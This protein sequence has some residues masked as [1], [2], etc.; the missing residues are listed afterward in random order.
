MGTGW[1]WCCPGSG[2]WPKYVY[3]QG[4]GNRPDCARCAGCD[5]AEGSADLLLATA[6][7]RRR[8]WPTA[9]SDRRQSRHLASGLDDA[10]SIRILQI[11]YRGCPA[12]A[13]VSGSGA[14]GCFPINRGRDISLVNRNLPGRLQSPL[15]GRA[16][17]DGVARSIPATGP[18]STFL[19]GCLHWIPRFLTN[20]QSM[21]W[22]A[23]ETTSFSHSSHKFSGRAFA[24]AC[25]L[26]FGQILDDQIVR[27]PLV[28]G[29]HWHG[30]AGNASCDGQVA[31][32]LADKGAS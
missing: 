30:I 18:R 2:I 32:E 7:P 3:R 13:P 21:P 8:F 12:D 15:T 31:D 19:F 27:N 22:I 6:I 9:S 26:R 25:A 28:R 24:P 16:I 11:C 5:V 17:T 4:H 20:A 14:A 10:G 1:P 29:S 23:Q